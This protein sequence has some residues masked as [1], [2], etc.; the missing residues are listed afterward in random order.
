MANVGTDYLQIVPS[1]DGA[2]KSIQKTLSGM[3][4][5]G[6]Q[7]SIGN[8]LS[9]GFGKTL[10]SNISKA[11]DQAAIQT[12]KPLEA[13]LKGVTDAEANLAKAQNSRQKIVDQVA[14]SE[15]KLSDLQATGKEGT[16]AY[17]QAQRRLADQQNK[18][19]LSSWDVAAA[20]IGLESAQ[21]NVFKVSGE[22][23]Q[24]LAKQQTG[25][26]R[27]AITAPVVA[28]GLKTAGNALKDIGGKISD[29]GGKLTS[30]ITVP[31]LG[32]AT[33]VAALVGGLGFKRLVGIDTARGQFKGLGYDAD[34]VMK[35]VDRGVNETSLSMAEGASA[36]V[37]ILATGAV[38]LE[39]LESQI[40]R[41]ANVSAAYGVDASHANYLLNS[42]LTKQKVTWGD[43]AQMQ[44]NNI[45]IVMALADTFG[46]TGE[47]IEE[48]AQNGEISIDMLN[49]AL[50]NKAG[51]AALEYAKTWE[52][53][54]KNILSN[55]G[56]LGAK[57]MEPSFE[58]VKEK[59]ADFLAY[60]KTPEFATAA[61]SVGQSIANGLT[62]AIDMIQGLID[63]WNS[64]DTATQRMI[65]KLALVAVVAGPVLQ[66][67]GKIVSTAGT[68]IYGLGGIA[69]AVGKVAP[70]FAAAGGAGGAGGFLKVIGQFAGP[71]GIAIAAITALWTQSDGFKDG[72]KAVGETLMDVGKR[73]WEA[74]KPVIEK[75]KTAFLPVIEQIGDAV[76]DLLGTLTPILSQIGDLF[77]TV[78]EAAMPLID[79]LIDQ[80]VPAFENAVTVI[81]AVFDALGPIIQAAVDTISAIVDTWIA[82]FQGDWEAAGENLRAAAEASWEL[83]KS[84]VSGAID[85]IWTILSGWWEN[86]QTTWASVWGSIGSYLEVAWAAIKL[87]VTTAIESVKTSI[88]VTLESIKATWSG[89]WETVKSRFSAIWEGIK[90]GASSGVNAV[91]N[92][93]T[94]IKNRITGFFSGA[95]SWLIES[96]KS[97]MQGFADGIKAGVQ[98][99]V[100]AVSGAVAAVR[101]F[102]P[103]SPA[104]KG[105]FS[106]RGW[107]LYSGRSVVEA[108]AKG[109][110]SQTGLL[111]SAASSVM[112]R[113]QVALD[114]ASSFRA[115]LGSP[116]ASFAASNPGFP[117][118]LRVRSGRVELD[119]TD[120]FIDLVLAASGLGDADVDSKFG[121]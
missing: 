107:T 51:A 20:Q 46:Y 38:P 17:E 22:V 56:K 28:D 41:V 79:W 99:A 34:A 95:A 1:L 54:T 35:Q 40:K 117:S 53:V 109:M 47:Q 88:T 78:I 60:L 7:K 57:L 90:S 31:A 71:V 103:F 119:G 100:D 104:K 15:Q 82:I 76:G 114:N 43:L 65:G 83:I 39:G 3:D 102:L 67:F 97:L 27:I 115:R 61:E 8:S 21:K 37:S 33:A 29:V 12:K 59:A 112:A 48:M 5:S 49:Q 116:S 58:I 14:K 120:A 63:K 36:A 2:V 6:I 113:G 75:I 24:A 55:I 72:V 85:V 98:A 16:K 30:H 70:K 25:W 77:V 32:A 96:G 11:L 81:S 106:G 62:K 74:L 66:V 64:L 42:V 87:T 121:S 105:P 86:V 10:K 118:E 84:I 93:V 23:D 94:G 13:A 80:L 108:F 50:D 26:D 18:L 68:L 111:E 91:Y 9:S 19:S 44:R 4:M 101:D 69:G 45:P 92:T 52:G 73:I 89:A 110:T